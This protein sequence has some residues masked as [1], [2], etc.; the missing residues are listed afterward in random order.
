LLGLGKDKPSKSSLLVYC[1]IID[2]IASLELPHEIP[3]IFLPN[4][5]APFHLPF[6]AETLAFILQI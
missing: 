5:Q 2:I 6:T 4:P 3:P 1:C